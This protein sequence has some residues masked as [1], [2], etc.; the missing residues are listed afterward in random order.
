MR[1][2]EETSEELNVLGGGVVFSCWLCFFYA[3]AE[4]VTESFNRK[5]EL[6]IGM[7]GTRVWRR[8]RHD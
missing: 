2:E 3:I 6:W 4:F 7:V 8:A 1:E 5:N